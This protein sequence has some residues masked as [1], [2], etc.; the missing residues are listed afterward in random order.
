ML[1]NIPSQIQV[2]FNAATVVLG[3]MPTL[4]SSI[5]PSGAEIALL[6]FYRPV[7]GVLISMGAPA[8]WPSRLGEYS[9]PESVLGASHAR[10]EGALVLRIRPGYGPFLMS[11]LEYALVVSAVG[12]VVQTSLE[13]GR[14]SILAWGCTTTFG[15]FLW[16]MLACGVHLV[17]A[18]SFRFARGMKQQGRNADLGVV[19]G[20]RDREQRLRQKLA[21]L[22]RGS[23]MFLR[24]LR[25]QVEKEM[26]L[27][28]E[29]EIGE[30][31]IDAPIPLLAVLGNVIA[32]CAGFVH[33][34]F[35]IIIFSSLLFV[36]VWDVMNSILWRYVLSS[37]VCRLILVVEIAGLRRDRRE[38]MT[39]VL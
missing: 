26:M 22:R 33:L 30:Y 4:L 21:R 37:V 24:M 20:R 1:D 39:T 18:V 9:P 7:L 11:A 10:R 14:K 28:V 13:L 38:T 5:G 15:P 32:G 31:D 16:V 3:L 29:Q 12:N 36:S 34:T 19:D 8:V 27:C 23:V 35:G 6:G 2:N 25:R 17:A